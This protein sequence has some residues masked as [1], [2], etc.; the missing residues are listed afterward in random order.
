MKKC[1]KLKVYKDSK[2]INCDLEKAVM[3]AIKITFRDDIQ[4][5]A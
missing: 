3:N 4:I 2:I 5:Q 1:E